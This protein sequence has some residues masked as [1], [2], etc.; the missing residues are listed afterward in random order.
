MKKTLF[1]AF[2]LLVLSNFATAQSAEEIIAKHI[3]ATGGD[4]WS[5]VEAVKMEANIASESAAGMAIGWTMTSIRN[6]AAR[7]DVSVMGMNQ[8]S[9]VN[10]DKGWAT[11]PFM[12]QTDPEPLTADQVKSM[13]DQTD[14]DGTVIGYKE[15]GYT[16]EF[17]GKEDVEGTEALK[18]KVN[19]GGKKVEYILYD[20]ETYY[21]IKNIQVDEVDGKEVE[22]ATVFSNFKTVDGIVM[23]HSLQS[24]SP[25]MGNTTITLTKVTFNPTVD[26]T[27]FDMPKK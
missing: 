6:K 8:T 17:V 1:S 21:E 19:K 15:K 9:V 12:G 18:I 26:M 4:N 3:R 25:M 13:M 5:K 16:V 22:S 14:I 10:G 11:N 27:M 7:M 2:L 23:P 20:P 24:S